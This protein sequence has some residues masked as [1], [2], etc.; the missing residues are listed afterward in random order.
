MK[1]FFYYYYRALKYAMRYK[2][3]YFS[4]L[5]ALLLFLI[6]SNYT[7]F[8][9]RD[10][11]NT[12]QSG[13][14]FLMPLIY[15]A[16]LLAI[17]IILDPLNFFP[18]SLLHVRIVKD[19]MTELYTKIMSM[20]YEY[21]TKKET[22]K[23]ISKVINSDWVPR[24]YFW[25][26]E[27][28]LFE[29]LASFV[30]P[31]VLISVISRDVAIIIGIFVILVIPVML[32][33]LKINVD[34]R[35]IMKNDEY[36]RNAA[37][38]DGIGNYETVRLFARKDEEI[39][40]IKKLIQKVA[41]SM[42][43]Y[44]NSFRIIDFIS[45]FVG[46]LLFSV[47]MSY[48]YLNRGSFDL[49]SIVVIIT[50]TIQISNNLVG[51]VFK[52]RDMF[53][54]I[55][56]I[57][58]VFEILDTKKDVSEPNIPIEL[59]NP[60]GIID[61]EDVSFE[62][63]G[64]HIVLDDITFHIKAGETVALV[65]P[66]GGGK[67]TIARLIMRYY[68]PLNGHVKFD[69]VDLRDMG[70]DNVNKIIGAVPQE[71]V[72]FNRSI[73]YNIGY[74]ISTEEE[75]LEKHLDKIYDVAKKAQIH[76]FILTLPDGYNTMV[77]ERGIKLSGGQKQRIAI[78]R[79]LLKNPKIVVFDEATSMLDSESEFAIQKA[80][81]ELSRDTTTVVIAHRLSTIKNVDRIYVVDN[82][83]IVEEGKHEE[84]T[85]K[86]GGIYSHLWTLQSSGF[87]KGK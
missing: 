21:H 7:V 52:L 56:V 38:V 43:S 22:G 28:W 84:L 25:N 70:T 15:I 32:R 34:K 29:S 55:P 36:A 8:L 42:T 44:Q 61:F 3:L 86:V 51:F 5:T 62:Y 54:D 83:R 71:P 77:G 46:L 50:Y 14:D 58:D 39:N 40:Y 1:E 13:G 45:R 64:N 74:A 65:G 19:I 78:A 24:V 26:I 35:A 37:F 33:L 11:I 82:G 23:L 12:I 68:D 63:N 87:S 6:A 75:D 9:L 67:T 10:L 18:R 17:P 80:F 76:S 53:K 72:L 66:S 30:I 48:V 27:Y 16:I 73:L 57:A 85:K 79:V 4:A 41:I 20:D 69:G 81:K 60:K 2:F 31:L 59:E 49:G 47:A